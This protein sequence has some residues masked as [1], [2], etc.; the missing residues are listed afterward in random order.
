MPKDTPTTITD[1]LIEI[2]QTK[3]PE[4]WAKIQNA[5]NTQGVS[6]DV[7]E[8]LGHNPDDFNFGHGF[9]HCFRRKDGDVEYF[10]KYG[11][12]G[13]VTKELLAGVWTK[14]LVSGLVHWD[15]RK[16]HRAASDA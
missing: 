8:Y 7:I 12:D 14:A 11:T 16:E 6:L 13:P 3:W 4:L 9:G 10:L 15:A 1:D 2:I 5:A